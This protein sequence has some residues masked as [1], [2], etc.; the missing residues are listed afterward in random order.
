MKKSVGVLLL[1]M[2]LLAVLMAPAATAEEYD[3]HPHNIF[4][5]CVCNGNVE[6]HVCE[7]VLDWYP[8]EGEVNFGT[9]ESGYYYLTGD[10]T[11]ISV[12]DEFIGR[13]TKND[14]GSYTCTQTTDLTIC[15]NGYDI[16]A[17]GSRVFMGVTQ[18]SSLTITDCAYDPNDTSRGGTV[19][20]G[21]NANGGIIYTYAKSEFNIYGGNFTAKAGTTMANG[22]LIVIAQDRGDVP[23]STSVE[24]QYSVFNLYNG[25]FYGGSAKNG[26]NFSFMHD[27][28]VNI[29]GGLIENGTATGNG[30]NIHCGAY[31]L[32]QMHG[33]EQ[34]PVVIR[35]GNAGYG[36][37][38]YMNHTAATISLAAISNTALYDGTAV[39]S[40]GNLRIVGTP[41]LPGVTLNNSTPE[42][43]AVWNGS[44]LIGQYT[45]LADAVAA[46]GTSSANYVQLL[47]DVT[48]TTTV[49]GDLYIDL[50]GHTLSGLTVTGTV[51]GMD[52]ATNK[53]DDTGAGSMTVTGTVAS[54]YK[55]TAAQTG[56]IYR[57]LTVKS[58]SS[59]SFHRYYMGVTS[60]VL[61]PNNDGMG[62]KATFAGSDTVKA[63]LQD[64][65]MGVSFDPL[66]ESLEGNIYR[67][68]SGDKF[69]AGTPF[70]QKLIVKN[71]LKKDIPENHDYASTPIYARCFIRTK[72]GTTLFSAQLG[73]SLMELVENVD[74]HWTDYSATQKNAVADMLEQYPLSTG[75]WGIKNAH[76][77]DG[78][79]WKPW[80]G[81]WESGGH[82]YLT[83]NYTLSS[84]ITVSAGQKLTICL[85]GYRFQGTSSRMFKVLGTLN[86][87]DHREDDGSYKGKLVS[88]YSTPVMAPV[89][90]VY[91]NGVMNV[92]GGNLTYEGTGVMTRG[93]IGMI[94]S[95]DQSSD[96]NSTEDPAYF[97]MYYGKICG[98]KV[99]ATVVDGAVSGA[100][101]GLGG[102]LDLV[103]HGVATLYRG[104][105]S[106]GT[107]TYVEA[108]G[109]NGMGGNICVSSTNATL[110][111]HSV[112]ITGGSS[113]VHV[114]SGM[115]NLYDDVNIT[116]NTDYN[117][118]ISNNKTITANNLKDAA[119]GVTT[120]GTAVFATVTDSAYA[121][122]F[123][124]DQPHVW[125]VNTDGALNIC[126]GH[127]V[128][129]NCAEGVGDHS[130]EALIYK[131][132]PTG[133]VNLGTLKAG[134]YY[135]TG[136]IVATGISNFSNKDVKICLNGYS[137]KPGS[138]VDAPLGRV[139][140]GAQLHICD[141]SGEKDA[142]GN[143]T[144]GGSIYAGT[145]NYGGVTN[146]NANGKLYIYGGNFIGTTGNVSGGVFN[147]CNDGHGGEDGDQYLDIYDTQ[148]NMYN[149]LI[150]GGNVT[151]DGGAINS[152]HHIKVNIYGGTIQGGTAGEEGGNFCTSGKWNIENAVIK[153][154]TAT[155][156][157]GNIHVSN[158]AEVR[159]KNTTVSGGK[160]TEKGGNISMKSNSHLHLGN[161]TVTGG[162][163]P[164]G[165]GVFNYMATVHVSGNTVINNNSGHN[166][167][168]FL[169][170]AIDVGTMGSSAKIGVYSE[171]KGLLLNTTSYTSRFF[172][173]DSNYS[174]VAFN[175]NTMYLKKGTTLS[176]T[177]PT[178]FSAGYGEVDISPTENGVPLAGYGTSSARLST[179]VDSNGRLYVMTT[180]VT[181]KNGNTVLIVACD[182]I[183]FTDTVTDILREHMSAATGVPV[184]NIYINCSH[185]HSAPDP[186]STDDVSLRYRS[187][188]YSGFVQSAILAMKDRKSATM[189]TG[190]FDLTGPKGTG[191]LNFTRHYQYTVNGVV[192]YFG[193]NFGTAKY[194]STTKPVDEPDPTMH[195][196]KFVRSGTDILLCNWRAHPHFTGGGAKTL[197]SSDY[198]GPFRDQAE[199]LLGDVEVV[200]IQGAGGNMNEKSR[201]SSLN[202]G[203]SGDTA[204]VQ[205]GHEMARQLK[206]NIGVLKTAS[207][208]TIQTKQIKFVGTIDHETDVLIDQAKEV[209][210]TYWDL[211]TDARKALLAK[212]GFTSVYHA[213]AIVAR[214]NMPD[215]KEMEINVF[216]IGKT[217]G[218][219]TVPGELWCSASE[220]M[221]AA[222][223][224]PITFC[225]GY[226]LGDYKY[227]TYKTAWNYESYEG[228]NYRFTVPDTLNKMLSYWKSGLKELYNKVS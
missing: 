179:Q 190:S 209:Q 187:M 71:I 145:R 74:D 207:T 153:N 205:Y 41:E 103:N 29:Y 149:G 54:A 147:I 116:G 176:Y 24:D 90:Y 170:K 203:Y 36:G 84:T 13:V 76:H 102:N 92:S 202:H 121:D 62:Y 123:T 222:S 195:L 81:T 148:L 132:I 28:H 174:L 216:S 39:T 104:T 70:T 210:S 20:G 48:E 21:N 6:G 58:G 112:E 66:A 88:T 11:A 168:Q 16:T 114:I 117:L 220:E 142:S 35:G 51:Y 26:G 45:T 9:L 59:Y 75:G 89:F 164:I 228:A 79:V 157:G 161:T 40:N 8:L 194:D 139:R 185:T 31:V 146:V 19:T 101:Q 191:T 128:C 93:G 14:D 172:S 27:V 63:Q 83:S 3:P 134:N 18:G 198:V 180:A 33:T 173:E 224:F 22:G 144:F 154:G 189:Q 32:L 127:C 138:S 60:V 135:L 199:S 133:T 97:N 73:G 98:G 184:Q 12:T 94:G 38:I 77:H 42:V 159:I 177:T 151:T 171:I 86:I 67:T 65:G 82:Y 163:A 167:H 78:Q 186:A 215:T 43:A 204:H 192:K 227:F 211:D 30:G 56:E 115:V 150:Q 218:F 226:S 47:N 213:G 91:E 140:A 108:S 214:Y 156:E 1:L 125:V 105:V 99:M 201:I 136:D 200:F 221:E 25:H 208:G 129:G 46:A 212:Y 162:S 23:K 107:A 152:W 50:N 193:D 137:I 72:D 122:C 57:Y 183:R 80:T 120:P 197:V 219:Y 158:E 68:K 111:L 119:V 165:G 52:S 118:Y 15:L 196:I 96:S 188:M 2:L 64:F 143:W 5:H 217:V 126:H 69:T 110:N 17:A 155:T 223:P 44:R 95:G 4:G 34:K 166:L 141:C 106:G 130:C 61:S 175:G 7:H 182:Q 49:S 10:V 169:A 109:S 100:N 131:A 87:H 53:Y 85:N 55:S 178:T 225:V 113:G 160:A 37:N 124:A 206:N 181:D